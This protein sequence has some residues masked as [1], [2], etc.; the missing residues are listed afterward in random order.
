MAKSNEVV[1]V[2]E[3][4]LNALAGEMRTELFRP[5]EVP[6]TDKVRVS[7]GFPLRKGKGQHAIGQCFTDTVSKD[8]HFEVFISPE[9]N[10]PL[11]VAE[12]LLHELVHAAVGIPAGHKKPFAVV[13]G[14][15]GLEGKMTATYAGKP[16]TAK[17]GQIITTLPKWPHAAI[18]ITMMKKGSGPPK[19]STRMLKVVCM[20]ACGF[21][22]RTTQK[23]L[24][25]GLPDCRCGADLCVE[26][27]EGEEGGDD[28]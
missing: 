13:A 4:W 20:K 14:K 28:D 18:D 8:G 12:V 2:R 11:E 26:G 15:L 7:V 27:Q 23:I 25:A 10:T 17:L 16:L 3:Q 6:V 22:F 5:I 19:Q 1:V 9:L 24:D 21:Y